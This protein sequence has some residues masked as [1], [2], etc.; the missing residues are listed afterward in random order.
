MIEVAVEELQYSTAMTGNGSLI[1][2]ERS[3]ESGQDSRRVPQKIR[4][5]PAVP[6]RFEVAI[7]V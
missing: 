1:V 5:L 2:L 3:C 7:A 4:E 6:S